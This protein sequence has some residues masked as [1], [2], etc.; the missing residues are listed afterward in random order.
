MRGLEPILPSVRPGSAPVKRSDL[1]FLKRFSS[2]LGAAQQESI[3]LL[4][5]EV[6]ER[7]RE[8]GEHENAEKIAGGQRSHQFGTKGEKIGA[9]G[10][11]ENG[12]EPMRDA[13]GNLR[14]LQKGDNNAKQAKN[15]TGGDQATGIERPGA[16]F[17]FIFFLGGG[18][19]QRAD[20]AA[21]KH[22]SR[23]GDGKRSEE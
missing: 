13:S 4:A 18:F 19:D 10:Q 15:A 8:K 23:G 3:Q 12:C 20:E 14:V 1:E 7:G 21:G 16:G 2:A 11:A 9:P 6:E 17:A 22:G 5:G